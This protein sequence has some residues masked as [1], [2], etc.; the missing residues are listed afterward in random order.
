MALTTPYELTIN[1]KSIAHPHIAQFSASYRPNATPEASFY[2]HITGTVIT[3]IDVNVSHYRNVKHEKLM[4]FVVRIDGN[5]TKVVCPL[6]VQKFSFHIAKSS[7]KYVILTY[8][9]TLKFPLD[10]LQSF[11]FGSR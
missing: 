1:C 6:Q 10:K 11:F 3:Q 7:L 2:N 9:K 4:L 5:A 8:L